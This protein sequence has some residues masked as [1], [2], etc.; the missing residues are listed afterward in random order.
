MT[1]IN[2]KVIRQV[3]ILLLI[4]MLGGLIFQA[5]LPYFSGVL[6][7]ITIY[8]LLRRPM[9]KLV[10]KGWKTKWKNGKTCLDMILHPK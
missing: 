3:F 2:P 1:Q 10:E 9:E 7:A 4:I 8:V 5:I 6:G